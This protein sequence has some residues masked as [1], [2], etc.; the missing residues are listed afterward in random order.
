MTKV[1]ANPYTEALLQ[2]T[3]RLAFD[4]IMAMSAIDEKAPSQ[5][6]QLMK[7]FRDRFQELK[8]IFD[9]IQAPLQERK[10]SEQQTKHEDMS[11]S[12]DSS[13]Y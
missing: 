2:D 13:D 9:R 12:S 6:V 7:E 10:P 4:T 11:D 8:P 3:E 1:D 5:V